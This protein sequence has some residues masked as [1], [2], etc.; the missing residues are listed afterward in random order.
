MGTWL[1]QQLTM[2]SE[3]EIQE[4]MVSWEEP[5]R[6]EKNRQQWRSLVMII[7]VLGSD[8]DRLTDIWYSYFRIGNSDVLLL[9]SCVS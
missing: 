1:V 4:N 9:W 5:R 8:E 7:C 6:K 2:A 3:K